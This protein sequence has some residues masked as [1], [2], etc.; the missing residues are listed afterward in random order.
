M[1]Y[2]LE[3][4]EKN[5]VKLTIE[6]A[7]DVFE[8]GMKKSYQKNVKYINVPGFRKGKA[9]R[10]MIE[11]MYGAGV[12]YEDAVN[13]VI[14]DAY[15]NAVEEAKISPVSQ[16]EIDIVTIG[17]EDKPFV[18]TA[19]VYTKPEVKLGTYKGVEIAKV[20]FKITDEDVDAE[21]GN[22]R[23]KNSRM[24]TIEDRAAAMGDTTT[25]DF[26]GFVDGVAFE[27]GKGT[28]YELVLGSGSFIPGFEDQIV[29]KSIGEEF[30][31]N[32]KFP[33]EYHAE[34]LKG[35]DATFKVALKALKVKE[36]PELDD[37]FAKDNG[38]DTLADLKAD[39]R[40]K[41]EKNAAENEKREIENAALE[42]A[43]TEAEI[44]LPECMVDSQAER[45][46][47]DYAYR[48]KSQ[49]I[50]MKLYLQYTGMTEEQMKEQMKPS[51]KAQVL[52][53]L[54]LE[55]IAE[56][57]GLEATDEDVEAEFNKIAEVYKME[58]DKIREL[59]N[60][61]IETMKEDIV[62]NKALDILAANA[63]QVAKKAAK[64][65]AE[66][67]GEKK[68]AAKKTTTKKAETEGEKKPAAKKTTTKKAEAEGEKKPAAK[69]TTTKKAEAE[70]EK[71]PA[72]KKTTK[73][74]EDAE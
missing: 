20:E 17:E 72:A 41:L 22:M 24:V 47:E 21:I 29:G 35:K 16:P 26:E 49:G 71:K 15:D 50:D 61:N 8:E 57:E 43:V 33:E 63:K 48:L 9:P 54:V 10:K 44:D 37:E 12:F 14:P 42:A 58:K 55:K 53:S 3:N 65:A 34:E 31:V 2:T 59:M 39:V 70:G 18:F 52:G 60:A 28:D 38:F 36:L 45:M 27:G 6:V 62:R 73:K 74:A 64:K 56:V 46:V 51:A 68:P 19:E 1:S 66:A 5:K 32:V 4:V 25:I 69:K 7:A 30:D 11:K 40:A 67:E 13:F 23:E